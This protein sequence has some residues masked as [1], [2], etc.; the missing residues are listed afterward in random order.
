MS[1]KFD[2]VKKSVT[3]KALQRF[4]NM[5]SKRDTTREIT[6]VLFHMYL[7]SYRLHGSSYWLEKG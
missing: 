3:V 5:K 7:L 4:S 1:G 6:S 2:H